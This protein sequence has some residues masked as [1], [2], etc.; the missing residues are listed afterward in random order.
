LASAKKAK[1]L[2]LQTSI[3]INFSERIWPDREEAKEL[4][5]YLS[6]DP[7]V[8]LSE[9]DCYRLLQKLKISF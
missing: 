1:A 8:K 9:D 7:F 3:D 6:T 5:D 2:G 4:K